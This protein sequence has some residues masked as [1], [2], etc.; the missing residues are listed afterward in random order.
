M[1]LQS[2]TDFILFLLTREKGIGVCVL[3]VSDSRR[4]LGRTAEGDLAAL[5][6]VLGTGRGLCL[7]FPNELR[8]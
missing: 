8:H 3:F 1:L 6:T 4:V 2:L 5:C 7:S